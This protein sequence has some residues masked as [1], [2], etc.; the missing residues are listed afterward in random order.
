MAYHRTRATT[1]RR[2]K[3]LAGSSPKKAE[4]QSSVVDRPKQKSR[5]QDLGK[6]LVGCKKLICDAEHLL[7]QVISPVGIAKVTRKKNILGLV[8]RL[9]TSLAAMAQERP[10]DSDVSVAAASEMKS[11]CTAY[12]EKMLQIQPLILAMDPEVEEAG[13]APRLL[14]ALAHA[15]RSVEVPALEVRVVALQRA[16]AACLQ[17][18]DAWHSLWLALRADDA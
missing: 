8:D 14:E 10:D 12:H 16:V 6:L 15:T 2:K 1:S 11:E 7:A 3:Q 18:K 9:E 17:D 5:A 13:R 4:S